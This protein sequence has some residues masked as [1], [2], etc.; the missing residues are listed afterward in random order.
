MEEIV[1]L[2]T[3]PVVM[4]NCKVKMTVNALLDDANSK[5]NFKVSNSNSNVFNK[6]SKAFETLP[7]EFNLERLNGKNQSK[8]ICIQN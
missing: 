3:I 5:R 6:Q 2:R 8:G 1:S 4:S 7:I